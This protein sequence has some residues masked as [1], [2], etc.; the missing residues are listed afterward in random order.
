MQVAALYSGGGD[1]SAFWARGRETASGRATG[2]PSRAPLVGN[3]RGW[4]CVGRLGH[5]RAAQQGAARSSR[6]VGERGRLRASRVQS[7]YRGAG[8]CSTL[9]TRGRVC[10][11]AATARLRFSAPVGRARRLL[12]FA[13]GT[14]YL[15]GDAPARGKASLGHAGGARR[16]LGSVV[17]LRA[18]HAGLWPVLGCR[19]GRPGDPADP[20]ARL[21][22][23]GAGKRK[24][25]ARRVKYGCRTIPD[26]SLAARRDTSY[27]KANGP[28]EPGRG[29]C[30]RASEKTRQ[31][32]RQHEGVRRTSIQGRTHQ[33]PGAQKAPFLWARVR[34]PVRLR[35][36]HNR[37]VTNKA[38]A[39]FRRRGDV[40]TVL[41]K[42]SE[43]H[44]GRHTMPHI[45][46]CLLIFSFRLEGLVFCDPALSRGALPW[47]ALPPRARRAQLRRLGGARPPRFAPAPPYAG[48]YSGARGEAGQPPET[49]RLCALGPPARASASGTAPRRR[50]R[51]PRFCGFSARAAL[52][53][54]HRLRPTAVTSAPGCT[55][56][57]RATSAPLSSPPYAPRVVAP[58]AAE[59]RTLAPQRT[60]RVTSGL[61]TLKARVQGASP[62]RESKARVRC[63]LVYTRSQTDRTAWLHALYRRC[64]RIRIACT[65]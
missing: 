45:G 57:S 7:G 48:A 42:H 24:T 2:D 30:R 8:P 54:A 31:D 12:H 50:P 28:D 59:A 49:A 15:A 22:G 17:A 63:F 46:F 58:P 5:E 11:C 26:H 3:Y 38:A 40:L 25:R 27:S 55:P 33:A 61:E 43:R 35:I 36:A 60:A 13:T 41:H 20:A 14:S 1:R 29:A 18:P 23:A 52:R 9:K 19:S 34:L 44:K 37:R 21:A 6:V 47:P 62:R 51:A 65:R 39:R 53:G 4:S 32:G 16:A 10:H 64:L 56:L